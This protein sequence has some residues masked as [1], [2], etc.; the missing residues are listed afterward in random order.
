MFVS[1]KLTQNYI[2]MK[3]LI[4]DLIL[5]LVSWSIDSMLIIAMMRIMIVD[6][7]LRTDHGTGTLNFIN[8]PELI[9]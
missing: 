7:M 9:L 1:I 8:I 2:H 5:I 3:W 6:F 4:N